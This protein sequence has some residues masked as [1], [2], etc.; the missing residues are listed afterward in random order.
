[1]KK[2]LGVVTALS[3][4]CS[5]AFADVV[6]KGR[7]AISTNVFDYSKTDDA[8]KMF[9]GWDASDTDVWVNG[10]FADGL[11]GGQ[12]NITANKSLTGD[13]VVA[14]GDWDV[15]VKPV[16]FMTLKATN[17]AIRSI[18]R[19][20]GI[21]DKLSDGYGVLK[22]GNF[23][24]D[25]N[26]TGYS[27]LSNL[28]VSGSDADKLSGYMLDLNFGVAQ[29]ELA[30]SAD[31]ADGSANFTDAALDFSGD[32][33]VIGAGARLTIPVEGL[34]K[35]A[36]VYKTN[37]G[38][39]QEY[40]FEG[41]SGTFDVSRNVFGV[42]VDVL[43]IP[44]LNLAAGF[45]GDYTTLKPVAGDNSTVNLN[46]VDVR[47]QFAAGDLGL[48]L[49]N[50]VTFGSAAEASV[51]GLK[52]K[53]GLSY[54][55][56]EDITAVLE[57]ANTYM[58]IEDEAAD[59]LDVY[60]RVAINLHSNATLATGLKCTMDLITPETVDKRMNIAMPLSLTVSF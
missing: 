27:D 14:I 13:N 45:T 42:Y 16:D 47:A 17:C 29:V 31:E 5:V 33:P 44:G 49:H 30:L 25:G 57:T 51:M 52:T 19:Y 36:A 2:I 1:M 40:N 35:V 22:I 18:D 23:D 38:G 12:I 7:A 11:L 8:T 48:A 28:S 56:N 20:V 43:A 3:L 9:S 4:V 32:D 41:V 50:N 39:K 59:Y 54:A 53:F 15:W 60:P 24:E 46:G 58:K 6:V 10:E 55:V 37:M 21:L 34:L 26:L